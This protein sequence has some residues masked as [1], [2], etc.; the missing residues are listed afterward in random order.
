MRNHFLV[1][2][3]VIAGIL[4]CGLTS[5]EDAVKNFTLTD[6]DGN[7]VTL[8]EF[9][10][11][12]VVLEWTSWSCPFPIRHYKAK[13]MQ[14]LADKWMKKGVVWLAIN[15]TNYEDTESN[16]EHV[17]KFELPYPVLNDQ[18]GKVGKLYG[19]TNT[20]HMFVLDKDLKI[21]Y[22]G[23]I[24]DDISGEK[25]ADGK[26]LNY[27]DQA[28]TELMDDKSVSEPKTRAYG[29]SVKYP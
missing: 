11:K 18:S 29:C 4:G 22:Q 1:S 6:Q 28:L 13:N 20:P 23:A 21:V 27:V 14:Q 9:E 5:A 10:G 26:A 7:E 19:A 12:Y 24:D 3:M 15:S 16:K 17:K 25:L 2:S 8:K